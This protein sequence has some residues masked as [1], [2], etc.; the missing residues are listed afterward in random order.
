MNAVHNRDLK[1]DLKTHFHV[2]VQT[3]QGVVD[4]VTYSS[5]NVKGNANAN[6]E[7]TGKLFECLSHLLK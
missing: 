6:P 4:K 3:L 1:E 7:L 2:L 5:M